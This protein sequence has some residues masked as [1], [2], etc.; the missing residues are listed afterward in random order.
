MRT[1]LLGVLTAT[2]GLLATVLPVASAASA[3]TCPANVPAG[4]CEAVSHPVRDSVYPAPS[5]PAVDALHYRLRLDWQPA[6]H[7]LLGDETLTFRA[8]DRVPTVRLALAHRVQVSSVR[9][10]GRRADQDHPGGVLVVRHGAQRGSV[11]VLR[12][13]YATAPRAAEPLF[14][15]RNATGVFRTPAGDIFTNDEP[16]GASTWYAVNDQPSDKALY[17]FELRVPAPRVGVAN[18]RLVSRERVGDAVVTRFHLDRPAASYL[19]TA[20]FGR[21][22]VTRLRPLHGVPLTVWTPRHRPGLLHASRFLRRALAFDERHLGAYPFATLSVIVVPGYANGMENQALVTLGAVD[23][24]VS[25]E[26]LVHEIAHQWYGDTVTPRDWRDVWMNEGMATYLQ[27][28][29]DARTYHVGLTKLLR[30]SRVPEER[31]ARRDYGP[32]ANYDPSVFAAPNVYFGPELMWQE[33]REKVG[34]R[35]FW[36]MVR[37]WPGVHRYHNAGR[38]QYTRWIEHRLHRDLGGFFHAWLLGRASPKFH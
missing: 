9:L 33:L 27:D 36:S 14:A 6:R 32:P 29:W 24:L 11:H 15:Q 22:R 26:T 25:P 20:E 19:V 21:Y 7:R 17:D 31:K 18:G 13:R 8:A 3:A 1:R 2:A 16:V 12:I 23:G 4:W 28:A 10:D 35:P 30:W 5:H 38:V 37:A 34:S